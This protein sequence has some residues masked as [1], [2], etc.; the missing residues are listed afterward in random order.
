M[1]DEQDGHQKVHC[2]PKTPSSEDTQLGEKSGRDDI[3][4]GISGGYLSPTDTDLNNPVDK[5]LVHDDDDDDDDWENDPEN[6]RNW[7]ARKKWTAV[8]VVSF[9]TMGRG[10][11]CLLIFFFFSVVFLLYICSSPR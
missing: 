3:E 11:T 7:P 8:A 1:E 9:Q 6:G 10:S 2:D 4:A 5:P